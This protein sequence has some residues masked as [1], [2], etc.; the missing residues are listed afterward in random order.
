M[1]A[2]AGAAMLVLKQLCESFAVDTRQLQQLHLVGESPLLTTSF[3]VGVAAQSS[4]AAAVYSAYQLGEQ[5]GLRTPEILLG[6]HSAEQECVGYF[7]LD[8]HA[9]G[10]WAPLSGLY[11]CA[12]GFVR[13]HANFDHHRD[14]ACRLLGLRGD[15]SRYE[16]TDLVEALQGVKA[17]QF[18]DAAAAAGLPIYALR[19]FSD[20]DD[21][22]QAKW[23]E[24]QPLLT[25]KKIGDAP[26]RSLQG[27][28]TARTPLAGV[29][30]LDLTRIL[31]GPVAG[32][33]LAAYGADVMLVNSP[34]L[35][36]IAHIA[37]TSRGK[38]S[39]HID[40]TK[41]EG[42]EQMA[43][44]V[45]D[46]DVF[47]QG[48]RPGGLA[49]L[50]FAPD[51]LARINPGIVSVSLSAFGPGGPWQERRGFDSLVQ[52]ATG[53]NDAEAAAFQVSKPRELPVQIID[54]ASGFLMTFATN[55]ALCRQQQEGGSWQ[56]EVSLAQTAKWLREM[57][58]VTDEIPVQDLG[59]SAELRAEQSGFGYLQYVPHAPRV[60]G[61]PLLPTRS[62]NPPGT[63]PPRW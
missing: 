25:I 18:E 1:K 32:R 36:N 13:I 51:D 4:M 42:R 35:P 28:V 37:D 52:T 3:H 26:P 47:V 9:P 5:R 8:G 34:N 33:T 15:P 39:V 14:G 17:L 23:L 46:S 19:T 11:P 61:E 63:H 57:G 30:V 48:Y 20:W 45:A 58:R 49:E 60:D 44:L 41:A 50:G 10:K 56:V 59:L 16:S 12:D 6:M 7:K 38:R 62:S 29:R 21:H 53:F 55:V 22:P 27:E 54:F 40:L 2:N 24:R 31:A 43:N